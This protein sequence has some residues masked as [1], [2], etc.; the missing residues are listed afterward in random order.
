VD[1]LLT[2]TKGGHREFKMGWDLCLWRCAG[3][4][5]S[6]CA[7]R[8]FQ[9]LIVRILNTGDNMTKTIIASFALAL[10][11]LTSATSYADDVNW[12]TVKSDACGGFTVK[13]PGTP[14]EESAAEKEVILRTYSVNEWP[15]G[16]FTVACIVYLPG[17][18]VN[19]QDEL[20][21]NRD[22][23]NKES[24]ATL[25]SEATIT[26]Q[27]VPG[28]DFTSQSAKHRTN[29][30]VR[31]YAD[32]NRVYLASAGVKK[33]HDELIKIEQFLGSFHLTDR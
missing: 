27:G 9:T 22:N 21:T 32:G 1:K 20:T 11:F 24:E 18:K 26:L 2:P 5:G 15:E 14:K 10:L 29:Y 4:F 6:C 25:I 19:V 31:V 12:Q 30:R 7:H 16:I 13:M 3:A 28:L 8:L 17:A 23:F 33:G